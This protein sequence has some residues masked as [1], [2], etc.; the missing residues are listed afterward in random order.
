VRA[1]AGVDVRP[2]LAEIKAPS[3]IIQRQDDRIVRAAC[4]MY[5]SQHIAQSRLVMLPGADHPLWYGD[6]AAV[7]D[8]VERFI[9]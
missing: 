8:E 2:R 9:G 5:L 4:A 1:F 6:T 7:L 3:L